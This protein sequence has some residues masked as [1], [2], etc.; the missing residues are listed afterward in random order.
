MVSCGRQQEELQR[1][2]PYPLSYTFSQ[3]IRAVKGPTLLIIASSGGVGKAIQNTG[4]GEWLG[5]C[6]VQLS[7]NSFLG[8]MIWFYILLSL[9]GCFLNN[10]A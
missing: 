9:L 2:Q 10:N 7:F 3:A 1:V 8:L 4:L 5:D 6:F